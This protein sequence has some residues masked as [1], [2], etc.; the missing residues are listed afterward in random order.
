[1]DGGYVVMK[2]LAFVSFWLFVVDVVEVIGVL[3]KM[4]N[5]NFRSWE[6]IE[7]EER[8]MKEKDRIVKEVKL[9][10]GKKLDL[11][12]WQNGL[13]G[14]E[15]EE[16]RKQLKGLPRRVAGDWLTEEEAKILKFWKIKNLEKSLVFVKEGV[17]I[18]KKWLA[19]FN[20][21]TKNQKYSFYTK[22]SGFYFVARVILIQLVL[23]TLTNL[24]GL[25]LAIL[26]AYELYNFGMILKNLI[27]KIFFKNIFIAGSKLIMSFFIILYYLVALYIAIVNGGKKYGKVNPV[28]QQIGFYGFLVNVGGSMLMVVGKMGWM[29]WDV[30]RRLGKKKKGRKE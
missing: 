8:F 1:M 2:V 17:I 28:I 13:V 27:S 22:F 14:R 26:I 12:W 19:E 21:S 4:R 25:A 7:K 5:Y 11:D 24:P 9:K 23:V 16:I 6:E 18:Q 30:V 3:L 20:P 15:G 29:I 10:F